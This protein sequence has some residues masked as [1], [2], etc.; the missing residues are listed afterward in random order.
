MPLNS[1]AWELTRFHPDFIL[2]M[3]LMLM[4]DRF[5]TQFGGRHFRPSISVS[6]I[7]PCL[8]TIMSDTQVFPFFSKGGFLR[9]LACHGA[10]LH[11]VRAL[12]GPTTN[13]KMQSKVMRLIL[14]RVLS[15]I[16]STPMAVSCFKRCSRALLTYPV[17]FPQNPICVK[18]YDAEL[19]FCRLKN[20]WQ[21]LSLSTVFPEAKAILDISSANLSPDQMKTYDKL[22]MLIIF[23][24]LFESRNKVF[25]VLCKYFHLIKKYGIQRRCDDCFTLLRKRTEQKLQLQ[26]ASYDF[27]VYCYYLNCLTTKLLQHRE[28]KDNIVDDSIKLLEIFFLK[29][30]VRYSSKLDIDS[31]VSEFLGLSVLLQQ[32]DQETLLEQLKVV[33]RP[34]KRKK[35]SFCVS[36]PLHSSPEWIFQVLQLANSLNYPERFLMDAEE[37]V[38]QMEEGVSVEQKRKNRFAR[39]IILVIKF[40]NWSRSD[41]PYRHFI[42]DCVSSMKATRTTKNQDL[43]KLLDLQ[44]F[45]SLNTFHSLFKQ[46][47]KFADPSMGCCE[48]TERS[49]LCFFEMMHNVLSNERFFKSF[50]EFLITLQNEPSFLTIN[51]KY[52][53]FLNDLVKDPQLHLVIQNIAA[54][55]LTNCINCEIF[56]DPDNH[57]GI[58]SQCK[59]DIDDDD[60]DDYFYG[61]QLRRGDPRCLF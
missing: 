24:R 32:E 5:L 56:L 40:A 54:Y 35:L 37:I 3:F 7:V 33:P 31:R 38:R 27:E 28:L 10:T 16:A 57:E 53:C 60:D 21:I 29:M 12:C 6:P 11:L 46:F 13:H 1:R 18:M 55:R 50:Q 58:C 34:E 30:A 41:H 52:N 36:A 23:R 49:L 9:M 26:K 25:I 48:M 14:G 47:C 43:A 20:I 17:C 61:M 42:F 51:N 39:L 22:Y 8:L 15:G 59:D 2:V 19:I 4:H 45:Q 44:K